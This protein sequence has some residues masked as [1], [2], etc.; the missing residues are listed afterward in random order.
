MASRSFVI[1]VRD[2]WPCIQCHQVCGRADIGGLRNCARQSLSATALFS[3]I[4]NAAQAI[5]SF[6]RD[7]S[8]YESVTFLG[9]SSVAESGAN[10]DASRAGR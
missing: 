9:V 1:P 7:Q 8:M 4:D 2:T 10:H 3:P 6:D 5:R